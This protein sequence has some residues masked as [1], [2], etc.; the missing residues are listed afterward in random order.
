MSALQIRLT[1]FYEE[2]LV[3]FCSRDAEDGARERSP[4]SFIH[5]FIS[6]LSRAR[7]DGNVTLVSFTDDV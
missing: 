6:S 2:S 5:S 4:I 7:D 3:L 1:V